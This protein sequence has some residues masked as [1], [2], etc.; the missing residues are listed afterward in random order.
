MSGLPLKG[1]SYLDSPP[2]FKALLDTWYWHKW[3]T[4]PR[5]V[6]GLV[7]EAACRLGV[8]STLRS[9][10]LRESRPRGR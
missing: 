3:S 9:S 1:L 8:I 5:A 6:P 7:L 10:S 4:L 2:Y